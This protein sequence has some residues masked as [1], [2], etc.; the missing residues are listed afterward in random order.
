MEVERTG[1]GR[2]LNLDFPKWAHRMV[3]QF[4]IEPVPGP[5]PVAMQGNVHRGGVRNW[6]RIVGASLVA[7]AVVLFDLS[8]T[9]AGD[10][11][12]FNRDVRQILSENCFQ[13]HGPDRQARKAGLRLDDPDSAY[14][15]RDGI[16][17]VAPGHPQLSELVR[18]INAA[19]PD[20]RMPPEGSARQLTDAQKATL[21]RWIT[22]GAKYEKHWAF[23]PIIS[24]PLPSIPEA[25]ASLS[26]ID[27][28]LLKSLQ[29]K[30][31]SFSPEASRETL[32]RRLSFDLTGLPP[33]LEEIDDFVADRSRNGYERLVD[34]LLARESFGE[35][36]ASEWLDVAR[37]SDTYGYQV[38]R[39]RFVWPWRDW[40]IDA[41]N[42]NLPYNEFIIQQLAG[43][44]LPGA[45]ERQILATAFNRLHP[46]KVEGGSVPEEFRIEYVADRTQTAAT[47]F[48]GLTLE[49]ARCHDHK[50]DPLPQ[51]EYYQLT[52]FF[53][54]IDEAGLY[55][56][57]TDSV[58]TP[59]MALGAETQKAAIRR[60][61][62][63]T[64]PLR[65]EALN[66]AINAAT[67]DFILWLRGARSG[68]SAA[69]EGTAHFDFDARE[70]G[71]FPNR[72][73]PE[74]PATSSQANR[75]VPGKFGNGLQLTGDDEVDL[76]VGNFPRYQPF[77]FSLWIKI[78]EAYDRSVV[79][80]RSRAWTDAGSRGYQL[81]IEEG[82]PSF[83][84][85][86]F[87]P[88]N[89][90]RVRGAKPLAVD[91][92][93]HLGI[94][95]DGSSQ[96]RG[97][98][99]FV[100]GEA[101]DTEIVQDLLYKNITG[102]GHD[103]VAIGARFRDKGFRG[104]VVDDFRI[105]DR[106]LADIEMRQLY[107]GKSLKRLLRRSAKNLT[108]EETD[109]L[110]TYYLAA[111][112]R[113]VA[114]ARDALKAVRE[115][116]G[117]MENGLREIM[118]MKERSVSRTSY[119][120]ARGQYDVRT[121]PVSNDTPA[122]FPAFSEEWPRNR[123]GLAYWLTDRSHPL[124]ARVTVNRYWQMIFGI[125][126]VT[127]PEDFG[128][129]GNP[130]SHPELLDWLAADFIEHGWNLKRLLRQMVTSRAY[131][132]S[133]TAKAELVRADPENVWLGRA[134]KYRLAAEMIRDNALAVSGALVTKIG[135]NPVKPYEVTVSFKP[136]KADTG[137]GLYRRSLYT[138]WRRTA[139][140]P[141]MM[142]LDASK[143]D[144]CAVRRETTATPLQS[145]VFMNDPQFV[146]AA[147]LLA[148]R[149]MREV[150]ASDQERL[151]R[152]FRYLTSQRPGQRELAVL[153]GLLQE[154]KAYFAAEPDRV[155][156]FLSVGAATVPQERQTKELAA[157]ASVASAL[158]S[159]DKCL[160][161]Q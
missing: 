92:F 73:N 114:E 95:W 135:G 61:K 107:D 67:D 129:Q 9:Q 32:I 21:E 55:S 6:R 22:E 72:R 87:W 1:L 125:G 49:C 44:L 40:V 38:D 153:E 51:K 37:Y 84:L 97:L 4:R 131:R 98:R 101:V 85:I 28:F 48:M 42:R 15:D 62:D 151:I 152:M 108:Q 118:V 137:A 2:P 128:S 161:K 90:I 140:A 136:A 33:T 79:F 53:A 96:A 156:K 16:R 64:L 46:Q 11:L 120:L 56:Y 81:L 5:F 8:L 134:P 57:F 65:V 47:A 141:V 20:E 82:K 159:F 122:I 139:P 111:V 94:I 78:P 70:D 147:R 27:R 148:S 121:E 83:S 113:R 14:A 102:G 104:G 123:L 124:T 58:P 89:A 154:Q 91:R 41:F 150:E 145:F 3:A 39:D 77:S 142:V 36:M 130:P 35:R 18:R 23:E 155:A 132:Q 54:N 143:R 7:A 34:N 106:E 86:H 103:N 17:A 93:V 126:L 157:Y 117:R 19:D 105:Y 110:K 69:T 80:H 43:D 138:Y 127:T 88:G 119:I 24:P 144:V 76:K 112:D 50:Y 12:S 68:D 26:P 160:M 59:T 116:I 74:K 13:C 71:K 100:D 29:E 30:G 31:W 25:S 133:S 66:Q 149:V 146:E 99:L 63:E 115:Q 158:M 10:E 60:L 109:V 45:D 52:S 75:T